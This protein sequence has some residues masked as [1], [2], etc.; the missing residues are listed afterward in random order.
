V[1]PTHAEP[2][3]QLPTVE[4]VDQVPV[5]ELEAHEHEPGIL[6]DPVR[7]PTCAATVASPPE[8]HL[9]R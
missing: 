4:A 5:A 9:R 7:C 8:K 1:T 2:R 6:R 3:S